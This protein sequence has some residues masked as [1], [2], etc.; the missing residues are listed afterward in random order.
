MS[1]QTLATGLLND[2]Q[3][4]NGPP[5]EVIPFFSL[6]DPYFFL[7]SGQLFYFEFCQ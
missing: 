7:K 4:K 5:P 2:L 1:W 6:V 3:G